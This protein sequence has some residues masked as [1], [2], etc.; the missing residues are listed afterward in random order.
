MPRRESTKTKTKVARPQKR[1]TL[2]IEA[3]RYNEIVNDCQAYR[4]WL[5][6]MVAKRPELGSV[7]TSRTGGNFALDTFAT[8][9]VIFLPEPI[10]AGR[11]TWMTCVRLGTPCKRNKI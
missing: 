8:P 1:I 7:Q 11:T 10:Q 6:E 5:D 2:P 3:D 4:K 9:A